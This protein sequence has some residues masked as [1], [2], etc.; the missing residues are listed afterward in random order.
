MT[1]AAGDT[2]SLNIRSRIQMR[3]QLLVAAEDTSGE[4]QLQQVV[5]IGT[6]RLWLSGHVYVPTF[7]YM[8]QLALAGRDYRDGAASPLYDAFVD[9]RLHRD[10]SV[11]AGQYFVPF[12]RLRTVREWALQLAE[13]PRPVLEMTLDRDVGITLY[14]NTFLGDRSP[15]AFRLGAFGGGGTNLSTGRTPGGLFVGRVELRPLGPIDDDVESDLERREHPALAVGAAFALNF[16]TNR[17]RSTTGPTFLG[18]TTD[19]WH[20]AADS[21]F[22]WKGATLQA[23]WLWKQASSDAIVSFDAMGTPSVEAT[24]SGRGV[25]LQASYLF[26]RP[27]ELVGR[28]SRLWA[29]AGTDPAFVDE[30]AGRGDELAVGLN[31]YFNGHRLKLQASWIARMPRGFRIDHAAHLVVTQLDATF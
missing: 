14:S 7:T 13:R 12:D 23:E 4:R 16:N 15:V 22:K 28:A 10:L 5:N 17:L 26:P 19:Y 20:A 24:R 3:H 27:F 8:I 18:G 9:W 1:V 11:R 6:A 31:H 2:F 21:V 30:V 25:V 29:H